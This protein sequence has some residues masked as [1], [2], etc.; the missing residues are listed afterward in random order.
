LPG[1]INNDDS[2]TIY[3]NGAQIYYSSGS[4]C[5]GPTSIP[6]PGAKK[7]DT[8]RMRVGD[9]RGHHSG[10]SSIYMNNGSQYTQVIE[11]FNKA[12]T[13]GQ[14]NGVQFDQSFTISF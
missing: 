2:L 10:L 9:E 8:V 5:G 6:L 7:G 13:D 11:G 12:T 1:S 4:Y 14:D 3:L